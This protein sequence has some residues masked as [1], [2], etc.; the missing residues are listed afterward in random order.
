MFIGGRRERNVCHHIIFSSRQT[1]KT[2]PPFIICLRMFFKLH[3]IRIRFNQVPATYDLHLN[4]FF[5]I[6]RHW[7]QQHPV[8]RGHML[9]AIIHAQI[10]LPTNTCGAFAGIRSIF[11]VDIFCLALIGLGTTHH[12]EPHQQENNRSCHIG[13]LLKN[14]KVGTAPNT[15]KTPQRYR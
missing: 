3:R 13:L 15:P 12:H 4:R 7:R 11:L 9:L 10:G 8:A 14:Q 1:R 5:C 2:K 6:G